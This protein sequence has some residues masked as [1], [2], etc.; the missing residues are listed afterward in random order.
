MLFDAILQTTKKIKK[1]FKVTRYML[2]TR[3]SQCI[4]YIIKCSNQRKRAHLG[5]IST[6]LF[7]SLKYDVW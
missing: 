6:W 2:S 3:L 7:I 4:H 5:K 1:A